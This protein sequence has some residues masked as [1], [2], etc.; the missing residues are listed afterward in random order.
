LI[1]N[2]G[3]YVILAFRCSSRCRNR[4]RVWNFR[5]RG[6]LFTISNCSQKI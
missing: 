5:L 2:V 1:L 3:F 4:H 6:R